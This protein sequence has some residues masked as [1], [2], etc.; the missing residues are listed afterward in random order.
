[1][2]AEQT[3]V[4]DLIAGSTSPSQT[5]KQRIDRRLTILRNW[6]DEGIPFAKDIPKSLTAA[7]LWHDEEIGILKIS[8]PNEFTQRHAFNGKDVRA[9]AG[10]LTAL[11]KKFGKPGKPARQASSAASA[12]FDRHV[13]DAQLNAAVSQWHSQRD[14]RLSEERRRQA[15]DGRVMLLND[16]LKAKD[17]LIADLTRRLSDRG[18]LRSVK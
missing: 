11:K 17:D 5:V 4:V 10:L 9:I 14:G 2:S 8:S 16:D 12:K 3:L 6:L 1:M 18:P 13:F 7:R 15:A